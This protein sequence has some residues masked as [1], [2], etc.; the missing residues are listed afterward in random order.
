MT[1]QLVLFPHKPSLSHEARRYLESKGR[2][3][4]LSAKTVTKDGVTTTTVLWSDGVIT[5]KEVRHAR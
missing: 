1:A 4:F 5:T 3:S 2:I